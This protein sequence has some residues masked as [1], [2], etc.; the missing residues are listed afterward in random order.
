MAK[1]PL[2]KNQRDFLFMLKKR[3]E[4]GFRFGGLANART[5][6]SLKK[7]GLVEVEGGFAF[8]TFAGQSRAR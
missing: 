3:G 1:Q 7:R 6:K 5:I 2:T 4:D 8:L